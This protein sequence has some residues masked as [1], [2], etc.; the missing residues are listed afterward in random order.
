MA[1]RG[2]ETRAWLRG[3]L[4]FPWQ[5]GGVSAPWEGSLP[6]QGLPSRRALG[7]PPRPWSRGQKFRIGQEGV[8]GGPLPS[9]TGA[10]QSLPGRGWSCPARLRSPS[11][12]HRPRTRARSRCRAPALP[13]PR[14]RT[15]DRVGFHARS[16]PRRVSRHARRTRPRNAGRAPS[17]RR[18]ARAGGPLRTSLR[19]RS[20]LSFVT[21][22]PTSRPLHTRS[23]TNSPTHSV[24]R[25]QDTPAT[26]WHQPSLVQPASQRTRTHVDGD[27]D[28]HA[29]TSVT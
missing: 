24:T 10:P 7:K 15:H 20:L 17:R 29:G 21:L 2:E 16:D 22:T 25:T 1:G 9:F 6:Q 12:R 13:P 28:N 14:A 19:P 11:P 5:L 18:T 26:S 4:W 23:Q 3:K 27:A 8:N